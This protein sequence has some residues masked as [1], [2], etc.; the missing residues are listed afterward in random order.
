MNKIEIKKGDCLKLL[1]KLDDG[2]IDMIFA[3]PPYNLSGKNNQT[4]KSGK[5]T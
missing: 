2:S 1:K 3:D 4:V 5:M